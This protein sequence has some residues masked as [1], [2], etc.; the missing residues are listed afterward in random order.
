[1]QEKTTGDLMRELESGTE[2]TD[3]LCCNSGSLL[4]PDVA[5]RLGELRQRRRISKAALAKRARISEVYLHQV[6][7]GRRKPSR[8]T[9]LC[10]CIALEASLEEVQE[11]L[12]QS[13]YAPLYP[14]LKRDAVIIYELAHGAELDEINN[15]LQG[16][17]EEPLA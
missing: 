9:L 16:A 3:Y 6:F 1:M 2:L 5:V 14:R 15:R 7:A 17:G 10:I 11:L 12:K 4:E 8:N 13:S